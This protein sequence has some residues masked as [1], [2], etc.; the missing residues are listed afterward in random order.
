MA[1]QG[2]W[3]R[4]V[5]SCLSAGVLLVN[6]GCLSF[7]NAVHKPPA[8]E[9]VL[10][11]LE[12]PKPCRDHVHIFLVHGM[13]PLDSANLAGV[14]DYLH[15]LGFNQVYYGQLYHTG[16]FKKEVRRIHR[17]DAEAR[18]AL[19]GFSFG[20]NMVRNIAQDA[21]ADGIHI[22]LLVYLGGNTLDNIPHDRPENAG[23]IVNILAK[24]CIW[25]GAQLDGAENINVPDVYHF[26]S[27]TH[28]ATLQM[29]NRELA[30]IAVA[31]P[32]VEIQPPPQIP[33]DAE[34]TPRPIQLP[35]ASASASGEWDFLK[36]VARLEL[37]ESIPSK[38]APVMAAPGEV[39]AI[40][41]SFVKRP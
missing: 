4:R 9:A 11:C 10:S 18:F 22:D 38:S 17:E 15:S 23:H 12:V 35:A 3:G 6:S 24:G 21:K 37:P 41:T 40:K 27:P 26:G 25:N 7:L 28:P 14:R 16:H 13:D 29:L 32:I 33:E 34:P 1:Q 5:L 30:R 36:P 39:S 31:V 19:I 2:C 8:E 20:A